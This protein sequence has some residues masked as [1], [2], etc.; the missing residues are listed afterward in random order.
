MND[1]I[2]AI[3]IE[4]TNV[5]SVAH[6]GRGHAPEQRDRNQSRDRQPDDRRLIRETKRRVQRDAGAPLASTFMSTR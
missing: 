2:D 3:A 6:R 4:T 5:A 1:W